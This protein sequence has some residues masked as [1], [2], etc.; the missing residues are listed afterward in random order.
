M[1]ISMKDNKE[2]AIKIVRTQDDEMIHNVK[3][4]KLFCR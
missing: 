1:G 2:Y 3:I 4:N